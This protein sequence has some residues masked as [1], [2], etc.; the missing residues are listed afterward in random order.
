MESKR[1]NFEYSDLI[2]L[3]EKDY[4]SFLINGATDTFLNNNHYVIPKTT[5]SI[6]FPKGTVIDAIHCQ[7]K[8]IHTQSINKSVRITP[9]IQ[10]LNN[11]I[12]TNI[13]KDTFGPQSIETWFDYRIGYGI[14][15]NIPS[16]II[17]LQTYPVQYHPDTYE[18]NWAENIEIS[19]DYHQISHLTNSADEYQYLIITSDDFTTTLESLV[20]HKND[21][22]ISTKL[23]TLNEIYAGSYFPVEGRDQAENIKYFIKNAYDNWGIRSV[24]LVGG[25]DYFPVR[26]CHLEVVD[27]GETYTCVMVSDLYFADI[28]DENMVFQTW[29][30]NENDVFGEYN[31]NEEYD[32]IDLYPDV[33]IGRLPCNNNNELESVIQKIITY[34][35][36]K[37]YAQD[38]FSDFVVIGGDSAPDDEEEIDE[39][40]YANDKAIEV[41]DGFV[42][43]RIWASNGD[44]YSKA[45]MNKAINEGCGFVYFSGHGSRT[46][47]A[48]HPHN[49]HN[50]W[51]PPGNYRSFD[52]GI[53]DNK[54][55]LPIVILDACYVGQFDQ[56][57]DCFSWSFLRN[58][59]GGCISIFS[60][61]D[62]SYFYPTSYVTEDIIGKM[63]QDT[64]K[65]Y[66]L[67]D[68]I[69]VGEM[70]TNGL[71]RY[72]SPDM[73]GADYFTCEE[74]LL[75]GDPSLKI[76]KASIPPA[77]PNLNGP[78][79]GK[80]GGSSLY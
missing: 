58:P 17:T 19:I 28:Y 60:S 22:G 56:E 76:A 29:D 44:L 74:W 24:L 10:S 6:H 51:L 2:V 25:S 36:N 49:N 4:T 73:D 55:E 79:D 68:A 48:T 39:G 20:M 75:M 42:P 32:D 23:I 7:P 64:I 14:I 57:K 67:D 38:W 15:D 12:S 46:I 9:S 26:K 27:E 71:N 53:L 18:I 47:W 30:T 63:A 69:T 80:T 33:H 11:K 61:T 35:N 1:I 41:M 40:E 34:E 59:N 72:I 37:A 77:K 45:P 54:E 62:T 31:W 50:I 52:V 13:M 21:L 65:G 3:E 78:T 16:V 70:W 8:A 5:T 43:K 66:K